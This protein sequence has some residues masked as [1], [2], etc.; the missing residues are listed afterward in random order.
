MEG[1]RPNRCRSDRRAVG[2]DGGL[3]HPI[4][5]RTAPRA[6]GRRLSSR[7]QRRAGRGRPSNSR[8]SRSIRVHR[9]WPRRAASSQIAGAGVVQ[10]VDAI[11]IQGGRGQQSRRRGARRRQDGAERTLGSAK[12]IGT[13]VASW[14]GWRGASPGAVPTDNRIRAYGAPAK[15]GQG[16]ARRLRVPAATS[17]MTTVI[18]R[19]AYGGGGSPRPAWL[20]IETFSG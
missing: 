2:P 12:W 15:T 1:S 19:W 4:D 20:K 13:L 14:L 8:S 11:R 10:L 7:L 5:P 6:R 16:S 9:P 3:R 17:C 18:H